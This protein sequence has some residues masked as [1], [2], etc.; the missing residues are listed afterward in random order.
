MKLDLTQLSTLLPECR[1][2]PDK[3]IMLQ[4]TLSERTLWY[5]TAGGRYL[6]DCCL[7]GPRDAANTGMLAPGHAPWA[8]D[9]E[10]ASKLWDISLQMVGI[11]E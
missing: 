9:T 1:Q 3:L 11:A 4:H 7:P 10:A 5:Q 2:Q 8:Y 6:E